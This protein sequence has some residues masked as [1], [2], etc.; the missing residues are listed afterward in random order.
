MLSRDNAVILLESN[1]AGAALKNLL[2][3]QGASTPSDSLQSE[4][5]LLLKTENGKQSYVFVQ[6]FSLLDKCIVTYETPV[7]QQI[8][9]ERVYSFNDI[10]ATLK[11]KNSI[12]RE[13]VFLGM[14]LQ[15]HER[16]LIFSDIL[17]ID[18]YK[19]VSPVKI[20][21][22][23]DQIAKI[24]QEKAANEHQ[25]E[26][27]RYY[28]AYLLKSGQFDPNYKNEV[29]GKYGEKELQQLFTEYSSEELEKKSIGHSSAVTR[30][31]K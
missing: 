1:K 26:Y 17:F 29:F 12:L 3:G 20:S 23:E 22:L 7:E 8:W 11:S 2:P 19:I 28:V 27:D 16:P 24:E 9:K 4:Y 21:V 6:F 31:K 14:N 30:Y 5:R 13:G 15:L 18:G 25:L 10:F